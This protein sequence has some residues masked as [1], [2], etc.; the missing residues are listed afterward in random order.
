[1]EHI[2]LTMIM[3]STGERTEQWEAVRGAEKSGGTKGTSSAILE[4][5]WNAS[6]NRTH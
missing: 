6:F 5:P 1:M 4:S 3:S 2:G